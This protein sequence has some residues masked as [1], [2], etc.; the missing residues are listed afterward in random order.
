MKCKEKDAFI[1]ALDEARNFVHAR[2]EGK[3]A[4]KTPKEILKEL[5]ENR[6][7]SYVSGIT[8]LIIV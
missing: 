2:A 3:F 4:D 7:K 5:T 8:K 1:L 6:P